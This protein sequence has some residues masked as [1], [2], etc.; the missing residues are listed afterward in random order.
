MI[1]THGER[2]GKLLI[3]L[4]FILM[5][6]FCVVPFLYVVSASLTSAEGLKQNGYTLIPSE[7]STEAYEY[8]MKSGKSLLQAYGVTIVV[9]VSGTFL[10]L[11]FTSMLGYVTSRRDFSLHRQIGFIVFFTMLF[12][13]GMVPSYILYTKYYHLRDTIW[14]LFLPGA[15]GAWNVFL[16]KGFFVN[17]PTSLLEASKLDGCTEFGTFFRIV[18]PISKPAF[19]TVGLFMA[20]NYWNS[21]WDSMMYTTKNELVTLQYYLQ[22]IMNNIAMLQE[23]LLRGV[24]VSVDVN[25]IPTESAR[26]ALCVLVAGPIL[27]VF[28]FFQKHFVK[29]MAVGSVKE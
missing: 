21:W 6:L 24:K 19:A 12:S 23:A 14:V 11:L 8:C 13:G 28:P 16:M 15:V 1:E 5:S 2:I 3:H 27:L 22:R 18:V 17:V 29:G 25:A 26:M 10:G 9:T 7:F 4:I 20:F